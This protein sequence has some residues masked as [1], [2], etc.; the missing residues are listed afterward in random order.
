MQQLWI[1]NSENLIVEVHHP[2]VQLPLYSRYEFSPFF[3]FCKTSQL[4]ICAQTEFRE[5]Y[6]GGT[7]SISLLEKC[8]IHPLYSLQWQTWILSFFLQNLPV[9]RFVLQPHW[10]WILIGMPNGATPWGGLAHH[11]VIS[12]LFKENLPPLCFPLQWFPAAAQQKL[13]GGIWCRT[14]LPTWMPSN[15]KE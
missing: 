15:C 9:K 5:P 2:S 13:L 11:G 6:C 14:T 7:P 4:N 3:F 1:L 8:T 10:N 12:P